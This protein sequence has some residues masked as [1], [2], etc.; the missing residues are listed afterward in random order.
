MTYEFSYN[1]NRFGMRASYSSSGVV[2]VN[3][4]DQDEALELAGPK[5]QREV[6]RRACFEPS[7][8]AVSDLQLIRTI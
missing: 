8:I 2:L 6:A 5:A 7:E 1:W 3:A 4:S